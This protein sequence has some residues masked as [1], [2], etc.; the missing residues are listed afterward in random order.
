[1]LVIIDTLMIKVHDCGYR[2]G[3]KGD[4]HSECIMVKNYTKVLVQFLCCQRFNVFKRYIIDPLL[5]LTLAKLNFWFYIVYFFS[6]MNKESVGLR[7]S[8]L[9]HSGQLR[10]PHLA[11]NRPMILFLYHR[12]VSIKKDIKE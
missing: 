8:P 9:S 2:K 6:L 7:L 10:N 3:R 11:C 5:I 12:T 4:S 1:M